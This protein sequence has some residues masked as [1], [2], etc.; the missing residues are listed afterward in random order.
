MRILI[1]GAGTI[2]YHLAA[3]L[4]A[5]GHDIVVID[6]NGERLHKL[7][8]SVDCQLVA[9]SALSPLVMESVGI[10]ST[11]LVIAVTQSD[12]TNMMI[13]RL[14]DYYRVPE[15]M[16]RVRNLE[17]AGDDCPVPTEHFGIDHIISPEL[18]T[19]EHIERL[20]LGPAPPKPWILKMAASPCAASP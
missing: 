1:A 15:K 4:A 5:E 7:E 9:G 3:S 2:G 11:D 13:C 14:A 6:E 20:V 8:N 18:L 19:V 12:A 16:A 17:M 10:R